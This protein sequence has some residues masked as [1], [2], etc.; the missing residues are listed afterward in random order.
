MQSLADN[1]L[2]DAASQDGFTICEATIG[3][4]A[5]TLEL[6]LVSSACFGIRCLKEGNSTAVAQLPSPLPEL[7]ATVTLGPW[8]ART[9]ELFFIP[10]PYLV[11]CRCL[12]NMMEALPQS[13][14]NIVYGGAVPVLCSK[15]LEISFIDLAEQCLS[16]SAVFYFE[17]YGMADVFLDPGK[18]FCRLPQ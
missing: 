17:K 4:H 5:R 13:T 2:P 11:A 7:K 10:A 6:H 15:L 18:D 3:R 9:L 8:I 14:G 12:A 1:E 16:V